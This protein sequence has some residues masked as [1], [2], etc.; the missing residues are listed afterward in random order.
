[1][2]GANLAHRIQNNRHNI[3]VLMAA[4]PYLELV[5]HLLNAALTS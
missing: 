4:S 3:P 2:H 5:K 1:M